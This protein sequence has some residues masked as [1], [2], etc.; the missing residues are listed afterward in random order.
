MTNVS[1]K[2]DKYPA[3]FWGI[4][5]HNNDSMLYPLIETEHFEQ[6]LC[7]C[8]RE[9][10][11]GFMRTF[12][13]FD[14]WSKEAMDA[15]AEYY[16]K[17]QKVTDTPIY[18]AGG[19]AKMH[20]NDED[21]KLYCERVA[22]NLEYLKKEKGVKHL[23]YY[24][25]SNELSYGTHAALRNDLPLLQKYHEYL[26]A[27]FQR[28]Q[29]NIGLLAPDANNY[30][31]WETANWVM[32]NMIGITED[33]SLHIYERDH[34]IYDLEFYDFFYNKCREVTDKT[35][36]CH[37][38]RLMITE[39]GI[40]QGATGKQLTFP[41]GM[42]A[43]TCR[44]F[45]NDFE[46]AYCALMISEMIFAAINAGVAAM[47]YWTFT[48]YPDPYSCAYTEKEGYAK[49]RSVCERCDE[50]TT[51]TKYNKWGLFKW[52]DNGDHGIREPYWCLAP[53]MK[54]F[55]RNSKVLHIQSDD[56]L[57][58]SCGVLNRD[59]SVSIGIVNRNKKD[60]KITL[61]STL[62]NK[63]IRVYEYDPR[64][65]PV[66]PFGDIQPCSAVLSPENATYVLK[67]ESVTFFTITGR[68]KKASARKTCP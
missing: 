11:P 14:D 66:N 52:E 51:D 45:E 6:L 16:Y 30:K 36:R 5:F 4:G 23:R 53:L 42:I 17:M 31:L 49:K 13:G 29:L 59:G 56:K 32:E 55:K 65:V 58:R 10:S 61:D 9:I 22:D 40:Q 28:R 47:A 68:R 12:G 33:I 44:Y 62:F 35:I 24:C 67:A 50:Y 7:K 19:M 25:Y 37:G 46:R 8:Y 15:F 1:V 54:L 3:V 41:N 20:F 57:L 39:F 63:G 26:Y 43:D 60:K 48:D 38:R 18:M 2:L 21:R 27:A 64:N 34:D